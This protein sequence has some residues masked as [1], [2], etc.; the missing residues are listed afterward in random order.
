MDSWHLS[1]LK[2]KKQN[3][4]IN[5]LAANLAQE[6]AEEASRRKTEFLALMSHEI[7]TPLN[8][9]LG[10]AELLAADNQ[11]NGE[12]S[13]ATE[14]FRRN[15]QAL[16]RL[17]D[18][19]LDLTKVESG[20]LTVE[21]L[22]FSL[23]E[24]IFDIIESMRV[25]AENKGLSF[26]CSAKSAIPERLATDP[27]RLCQILTNIIGNAIK[28][29]SV[30][31]V[32]LEIDFQMSPS[33]QVPSHLEFHI[34]DS[35]PG[36]SLEQQQKLFASFIQGDSSINR[37]F[38]GTGIGLE[39]SRRLARALGGDVTIIKSTLGEGSTFM[40][41]IDIGL[42]E[43]EVVLAPLSPRLRP[44]IEGPVYPGLSASDLSGTHILVVDDSPDNLFLL[45]YLLERAGSIVTVARDGQEG[46]ERALTDKPDLVFMDMRMP[47]MNG[48]EATAQLRKKDFHAPII[49]LTA[50]A[51]AE[52]RALCLEAGCDDCLLK[53]ANPVL[54]L[55]RAR[56]FISA[57]QA[58]S[59]V[60]NDMF[61]G[62]S[63]H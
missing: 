48:C 41:T 57:Y 31:F 5:Q 30:G 56:H 43:S 28:F 29:T 40:A 42:L 60:N 26:D 2:L 11:L 52:E 14:A 27:T 34:S 38:G 4:E 51:M 25:L 32:K 47:V 18:D 55:R 22:D 35:G 49:A 23:S 44:S 20:H 53:P 50:N 13:F 17:L 39:L 10:F 33:A 9:V 15:G 46:V 59:A 62:D 3:L 12:M 7:R 21:R 24:F 61:F 54:L 63:R 36:L 8:A 37:K 16:T 58:P 19:I 45:R 1:I 6:K